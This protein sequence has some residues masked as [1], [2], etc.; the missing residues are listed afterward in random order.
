MDFYEE[1]RRKL[2]TPQEA[3][4]VVK[5][6]D[7]IDYTSSLGKPV[8]LDQALAARRDELTDV[9][10]RGNLMAGPVHVAECDPGQEHF[11]YHSWHCSNYERKLWSKSMVKMAVRKGIITKEQYKEIT[12]E[13][14]R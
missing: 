14:Y 1:Y 10:I 7:W 5:S 9:K 11:I 4:T 3:V 2:R 13:D 12:G 6:G 8:L